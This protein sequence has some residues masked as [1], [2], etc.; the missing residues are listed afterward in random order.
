MNGP[1]TSEVRV[2]YRTEY[3]NAVGGFD[4]DHAQGELI[5]APGVQSQTVRI[6]IRNDASAEPSES[7]HFVLLNPTNAA[8]GTSRVLATIVD[9][10]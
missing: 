7:F 5:F 9:N 6:G 8:I 1:S 2:L 4:Y 10:D 3:A